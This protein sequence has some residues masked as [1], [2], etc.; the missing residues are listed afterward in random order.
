MK[1]IT[2]LASDV[3]AVAGRETKKRRRVD[4]RPAAGIINAAILSLVVWECIALIVKVWL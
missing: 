3:P 1:T 4:L 2:N